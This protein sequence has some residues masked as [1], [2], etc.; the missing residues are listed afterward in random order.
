MLLDAFYDMSNFDIWMYNTGNVTLKSYKDLLGDSFSFPNDLPVR[1]LNFFI[2]LSH[3]FEVD[4]KYILVHA[5]LNYISQK[6]MQD[7]NAMLW[8]RSQNIPK[9]FLPGKIIIHGHTPKP[10]NA[11]KNILNNTDSHTIPLDAGCVFGEIFEGLGY[12]VAL[13]L[14]SHK[15]FSVKKLENSVR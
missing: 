8:S 10:I 7:Y 5:G 15:L 2:Q 3:Y 9:D 4:S 14:E 11:I 13:E 12:L 1:H 6:P